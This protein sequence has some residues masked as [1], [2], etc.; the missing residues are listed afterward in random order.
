MLVLDF[1]TY[2]FIQFRNFSQVYLPKRIKRKKK[3]FFLLHI[4]YRHVKK[5]PL[6]AFTILSTKNRQERFFLFMLQKV[7]VRG[8]ILN[9]T[10]QGKCHEW[11]T[12]ACIFCEYTCTFF[13]SKL[14][15]LTHSLQCYQKNSILCT[16]DRPMLRWMS[17]MLERVRCVTM[18]MVRYTFFS[19]IL[20]FNL[21]LC[22]LW[23]TLNDWL[24]EWHAFIAHHSM[25][26]MFV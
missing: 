25:W 12:I 2:V 16:A 7:F 11:G 14:L 3:S 10:I 21:P 13:P 17:R 24:S 26:Y 1:T 22:H 20:S 6:N 4:F 23:F 9:E 19:S 5:F 8:R 15:S 18:L